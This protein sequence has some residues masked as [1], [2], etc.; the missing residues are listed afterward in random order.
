MRAL[1]APLLLFLLAGCGDSEPP[2]AKEPERK[3]TERRAAP[4]S[5]VVAVVRSTGWLD[6]MAKET[7]GPIYIHREALVADLVVVYA[8]HRSSS[9]DYLTT[10]QAKAFESDPKK[11][12]RRGVDTLRT[13]LP[14]LDL[15]EVA[16][17]V[18]ALQGDPTYVPS[19]LLMDEVWRAQ[20]ARVKGDIVA[21][22]PTRAGVL[23]AGSKNEAAVR[24]MREIAAKAAADAGYPISEMLLRRW[25]EGWVAHE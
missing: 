5:R 12:R 23:F 19:V 10:D 13:M 24:R 8:R 17:G 7:G 11:R 14:D 16:P 2:P 18:F 20:A 9:V 22:V 21:V 1:L 25:G 4:A 6:Q 3:T 15:D